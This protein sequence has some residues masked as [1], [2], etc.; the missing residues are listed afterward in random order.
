MEA[1]KEYLLTVICCALICTVILALTEEKKAQA[2]VI[3]L[4]AGVFMLIILIRPIKEIEFSSL[5]SWELPAFADAKEAIALGQ[6]LT[7]T[8]L[9]SGIKQNLEAYILEEA[10]RYDAEICVEINLTDSDPPAPASV[11]IS[12]AVSP[13]CK[14]RLSAY[15]ENTLGIAKEDQYWS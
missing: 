6:E 13:Y 3:R 8:T 12:G 14:N 7:D 1:I 4:L 9:R 2:F 5:S 15:L 11:T 10:S